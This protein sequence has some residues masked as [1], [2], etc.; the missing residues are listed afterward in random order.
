MSGFSDLVGAG[1]DCGPGNGMSG[2]MK[3]FD[4]DHSLEQA[5]QA[6][7]SK[8]AFRQTFR[9]TT[10]ATASNATTGALMAQTRTPQGLN[11][12]NFAE[13]HRELGGSRV[14]PPMAPQ[15]AWAADFAQHQMA[16]GSH[17]DLERAFTQ[18]SSG[19]VQGSH[20]VWA[21]QPRHTNTQM[22]GVAASMPPNPMALAFNDT[23]MHSMMPGPGL[24]QPGM[25]AGYP[26]QFQPLQQQ[27]QQQEQQGVS[28]QDGDLAKTAAQILGSVSDSANPK[29]KDSEFFSLMRQLADGKATVAGDQVVASDKA[30][31]DSAQTIGNEPTWATEFEKRADELIARENASQDGGL[32]SPELA[33]GLERNWA[34][35]FE[36][37]LDGPLKESTVSGDPRKTDVQLEQPTSDYVHGE[38]SSDWLEQFKDNIQP[39]LNQH[40]R[41]WL[42][43]QKEW[44]SLTS[45][46]TSHRAVD[47][48][49]SVYHFQRANYYEGMEPAALADTIQ[50][51][52]QNPE[53]A[54][55]GDTIMAMEAAVIQSPQDAAMW[56]RLGLK[57][58]ENEQ[59]QAAVAALRKAISLDPESLDAHLALGVSYTNE[60]YQADAYDELHEW[61]ARHPRYKS[62]VPES[63][64]AN[65]SNSDARK[66]YV[67]DLFIRAARMSPGQDWDA[68]VQ[69]ALGVLFNISTEYD[70]AVDCFK[71]ALSKRPDD[72]ILWNRLGA[73]QAHVG[74]NKEATAAYFRA[75]ELHPSF[76]RARYNMSLASTNMGQHR[77]A[78]ENCLIALSLQQRDMDAVDSK[79]KAANMDA[80]HM[81]PARGMSATIWN[82]LQLSMYM[83]GEPK[84]AEAC[85]RQD[86]D[87]F[88]TKFEF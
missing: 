52:R 88:R 16:N 47:P 14:R 51:M 66:G 75:L 9:Q 31:Q 2:L 28:R 56:L 85:E 60:G 79:G 37:T 34:E 55:L 82:A 21:D 24:M 29:L 67:Q 7:T 30:R 62:L 49:L 3:Q 50:H 4:R 26:M 76:I 17:A 15:A 80:A 63:A 38:A 25:A 77:E 68:D 33:R 72:Y 61:I 10:A 27:Q 18:A 11:P 23:R 58:Q 87:A 13:M 81:M 20:P 8:Q 69:V 19:R 45:L 43:T 74:S 46:E 35:E 84:L 73:T 22:S 64:S 78:A 5:T 48:E 71:A 39:M 57:Q 65:M 70:K 40:D 32:F 6:S 59:E 83:L 41:E 53:A 54:S 36:D 44:E 1:A 42:D 12:F 86:L